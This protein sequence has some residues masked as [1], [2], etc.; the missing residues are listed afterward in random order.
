MNSVH[1][2]NPVSVSFGLSKLF[3]DVVTHKSF[4]DL[5]YPFGNSYFNNGSAGVGPRGRTQASE[6]D[7]N[8][9]GD[10]GAHGFWRS[11]S[12]TI[13]DVLI[14]DTDASRTISVILQ[15]S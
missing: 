2:L 13:F 12:N 5:S 9:Q 1:D 11:G 15:K 4:G 3:K 8:L 14:V 10:V 7:A 6:L